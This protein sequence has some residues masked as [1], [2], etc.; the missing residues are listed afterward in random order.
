MKPLAMLSAMTLR[1]TGGWW[2]LS[3]RCA[4][5]GVVWAWQCCKASCSLLE[6]TWKG[7]RA[8]MQ[9]SVTTQEQRG[10]LVSEPGWSSLKVWLSLFKN[11]YNLCPPLCCGRVDIFSHFLTQVESS[12]THVD[13]SYEP[14][15]GGHQRHARCCDRGQ[16]QCHLCYWRLQWEGYPGNC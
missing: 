5:G 7:R 4:T 14:W 12:G 15:G 11:A 3:P 9:W 10:K 1:Q 6:G 2:M 16:F 8:L 13:P